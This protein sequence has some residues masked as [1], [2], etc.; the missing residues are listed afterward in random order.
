[1]KSVSEIQNLLAL[2]LSIHINTVDLNAD[3]EYYNSVFPD[4]SHLVAGLLYQ[5][6]NEEFPD[7][8][9]SGRW[10]DDSLLTKVKIDNQCIFIWGAIIWGKLNTTEQWTSPFYC[11]LAFNKA[12]DNFDSYAF[13]FGDLDDPELI[14]EEFVSNRG[15]WDKNYYSNTKWDPSERK[16][17]Y[18]IARRAN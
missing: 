12:F 15:H 6:L 11:E 13:F 2:R 18:V 8:Q 4:T 1:M 10:V 5:L 16:W 9:K 17:E 14:Y 7:W 3:K